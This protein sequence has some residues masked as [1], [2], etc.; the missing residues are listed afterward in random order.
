M[1][2]EEWLSS[3]GCYRGMLPDMILTGGEIGWGRLPVADLLEL[4]IAAVA[5]R[6]M[7][8]RSKLRNTA[9]TK[10]LTSIILLHGVCCHHAISASIVIHLPW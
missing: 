9:L 8:A 4:G 3:A 7:N 2:W 1:V 6:M 5:D 10:V